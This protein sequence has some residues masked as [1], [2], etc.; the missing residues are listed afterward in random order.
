MRPNPIHVLLVE[1][2][3]ADIYLISAALQLGAIPKEVH[4]VTDGDDA[5]LFVEQ[6]DRFAGAV[7]PDIILL[8]LNLPKRDGHA[9]LRHIKSS[10][11][12]QHIPVLVLTTSKR[13]RDV[14]CAYDAG[15]NCYLE[16]PM[17]LDEYF[18][19]VRQI[20]DYWLTHVQLC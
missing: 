6:R 3:P 11:R 19:V 12:L 14:E 7:E 13:D 8:D 5:I 2:N 1:D 16:K 17:D 18:E 10:R 9:V 4:T 20:E 15:A